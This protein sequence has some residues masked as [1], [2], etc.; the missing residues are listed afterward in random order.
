METL[1]PHGHLAHIH[2]LVTLVDKLDG[3]GP[4]ILPRGV[5]H[6]EPLILHQVMSLVTLYTAPCTCVNVL[7]PVLRMCQSRRR[8]Q[9]TCSNSQRSEVCMLLVTFDSLGA[10]KI[11]GEQ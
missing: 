6:C 7:G 2:P 3:Q 1:E 8:I 4:V 11:S 10:K 5:A 9:D